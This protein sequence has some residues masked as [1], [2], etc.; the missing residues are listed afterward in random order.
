MSFSTINMNKQPIINIGLL[1]AVSEG[2]SKCVQVLSGIKTQRH[3]SELKRNITV[4]QGYGNMKVWEKEGIYETT[5]STISDYEGYNLVNQISFVDCPGH[6]ELIQTMLASVSL[7]DGAIV[8]VAAD[9]PINRKPQLLQHLNAVKRSKMKKIIVCLNKIDL[10]S[11]DI[12][13][14]RKEELDELLEEYKIEPYCIIPTCFNKKINVSYLVR[15]IMQLFNPTEYVERTEAKPFFRISR[16]FDTNKPG[17]NWSSITGGVIGG[18]LFSG[19]LK[20]DDDIEIR[21]GI[22]SKNKEGKFIYEPIITKIISIQTDTNVLD[23]IIPG[24]LIGI[25]TTIDPFYCKNDA[26]IGSVAG[27]PGTL[28][29]VYNDI[30]VDVNEETLTEMNINDAIIL[31]IGTKICETKLVKID[32]NKYYFELAKPTCIAKEEHIIIC[33]NIDKILRIIGEGKLSN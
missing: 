20:K 17:T 8:I 29:D 16:T 27:I 31:Q 4:K 19:K 24:G 25:K 22:I 28:P 2:K 14:A 9:Q 12:L 26:L 15:A 32:S 18:C 21:P 7:M 23:E 10:V 1:G 11:K 6:Q 3:S 33:K 30:I 13:M 5:D